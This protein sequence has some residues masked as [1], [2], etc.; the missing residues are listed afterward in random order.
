M[1]YKAHLEEKE[2][3]VGKKQWIISYDQSVDVLIRI[4][5]NLVCNTHTTSITRHY[6]YFKFYEVHFSLLLLTEDSFS[7]SGVPS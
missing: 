1:I 5:K 6:T 7:Q 2:K 3:S 4:F